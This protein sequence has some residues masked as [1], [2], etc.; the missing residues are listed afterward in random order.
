MVLDTI[1][2]GG[3]QTVT[4]GPSQTAQWNLQSLTNAANPDVRATGSTRAGASS[5]PMSETFNGTSNWS[6]GALSVRPLQADVGVGITANGVFFPQ[7]VSYTITVTNNGPSTATGVT[8]T[9]TLAAGLTFV[10]STPSQGTCAGTSPIICNLGTITSGSSAT[11]IVVA[12]PSAPGSYVDTATVTATQPDLNG[13]NNSATA[14]A[15]VE[16][17]ACSNPAKNGNGGTLAGVINTY[18]PA[19]ANA[20]AGTTS[21]TVGASSGAAVP[22][23]IGDLLLVI[24]MQDAVINSTNTSSYGD[25]ST[26][27]G[28]T[29]LNNTGNYELVTATSAIPLGGGTVNISGTGSGGGLLYGYTNAAATATQGQ[30]KYQ[31][32]R[33]PQ[34]STATLTASAWNGSTGGILALDIAGTLNLGSATVSVDGLGFRGGAGLQLTGAAGANTDYLHTAPAAYAGAAVAGVDGTKGEGIA[35]TPRWVESGN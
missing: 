28:S 30:R 6:V 27:S 20:A 35:G 10:S 24:Q 14:V 13:G 9:D 33:I 4:L 5:V 18:Y 8:L 3:N 7:N 29:N 11:V 31:I 21:I 17:N 16:S 26:G 2:T 12:T 25:G 1:A 19:T 34:Y 22:I 32:V 23:A 15:F